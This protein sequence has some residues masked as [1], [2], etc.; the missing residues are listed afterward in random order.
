[1]RDRIFLFARS[2][3]QILSILALATG[4]IFFRLNHV[5]IIGDDG[6]YSFR[7]IGLAD[8]LMS[9]PQPTPMQWYEN[10][11]WW[12]FLSFHDHPLLLF[13]V[14]K[15]FFIFSHGQFNAVLPY[16]LFSLATIATTYAWVMKRYNKEVAI[17]AALLLTVSSDFITL[18]RR[19]LMEA[20]V[21]FFIVL[22]IYTF[23]L[24]LDDKRNWWK[25]GI[26]LGLLLEVKFTTLFIFP[27][28][29]SFILLNKNVRGN[30][31]IGKYLKKITIIVFLIALPVIIYNAKMYYDRG[32]FSYQFAR[33]F[34][35]NSPWQA[36]G[37]N[38][39]NPFETAGHLIIQFGHWFSFPF[40]IIT[41]VSLIYLIK[42]KKDTT[43]LICL[44][45]WLFLEDII[46]GAKDLYPIIFPVIIA[47]GMHEV[48]SEYKNSVYRKVCIVGGI[49]FFS[50]LMVYTVNSNHV[51]KSTGPVGWLRSSSE[52]RNYGL[53][54]LDAYLDALVP[55]AQKKGEI[56]TID[57]F[58]EVKIKAPTLER[59]FIRNRT[60]L[61][62]QIKNVILYDNNVN[63]F[64]RIWIFGR[65]LF[66]DNVS[67]VSTK[68][69]PL[70]VQT[71]GYT[72][73]ISYFIKATPHTYLDS[74]KYQIDTAT[75]IENELIRL[76]EKP[77]K[78]IYRD[79]GLEA[80]RIYKIKNAM[81]F[82]V[83]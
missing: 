70:M 83:E 21:I 5:D 60:L 53:S 28:F 77:I 69:L 81:D 61:D 14:Q 31:D 6:H 59:F 13:L 9:A 50:Y 8:F 44:L 78:I 29:L 52:P 23:I 41:T 37:V 66:Y 25:L 42:R 26:A 56:D 4:L 10:M 64:P 76:G 49:V 54:Q 45:F 15:I 12:S 22:S 82:Q 71:F 30:K 40:L 79:D 3:W 35:Q 17:L 57:V 36:G 65:R 24:F 27:A 20:G 18:A 63:W 19:P 33:L 80:F 32:H 75:T 16:T 39:S 48:Y 51:L 73:R 74:A 1:M 11:P 38:L 43:L 34:H 72:P 47:M 58:P 2:H 7:G 68:N 62:D 55:M 46:I 67:I